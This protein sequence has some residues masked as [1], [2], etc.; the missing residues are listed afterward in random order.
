MKHEQSLSLRFSSTIKTNCAVVRGSGE[1]GNYGMKGYIRDDI[2]MPTVP[3]KLR[4]A[5][6]QVGQPRSFILG[7]TRH[8]PDKGASRVR[9]D[10]GLG[11]VLA[12]I[13]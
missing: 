5:H 9:P 6:A 7:P 2:P 12:C 10:T 8:V 11:S 1:L 4:T 13:R 3:R